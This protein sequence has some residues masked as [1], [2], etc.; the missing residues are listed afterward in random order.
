MAIMKC[1]FLFLTLFILFESFSVVVAQ[2][3]TYSLS[4][5]S[6]E[7]V[8]Q[9]RE[10]FASN[11]KEVGDTSFTIYTQN[12]DLDIS[13]YLVHGDQYDNIYN[14][15]PTGLFINKKH[16]RFYCNL[17][18]SIP[19]NFS[20]VMQM[21]EFSYLSRNYIMMISFKEDCL[22]SICVYRCYNLFDV[23]DKNDIVQISFSSTFEGKE[24]FGEFNNDGSLDFVRLAPKMPAKSPKNSTIDHFLI[25]AFTIKDGTVMQLYKKKGVSSHYLWVKQVDKTNKK[26]Q[27]LRSDWFIPLN[28]ST[29]TSLKTKSYSSEYISFDPYYRHLFSPD[30]IRIQKRKWSVRVAKKQILE[31]AQ[32]YCRKLMQQDHIKDVY[33]MVDQYAGGIEFQIFVG[34][35]RSKISAKKMSDQLMQKSRLTTEVIN[36]RSKF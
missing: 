32:Q 7:G 19:Q 17:E 27:I 34:N 30:G 15:N 25:T 8:V 23:T 9:I 29:G 31:D 35:F 2:K 16:Y 20:N 36:I 3:K 5:L 11:F 33:I 28:D 24:T 13:I 14:P 22:G 1:K 4:D 12:S 10:I 21:I 26:F 18:K 6:Q